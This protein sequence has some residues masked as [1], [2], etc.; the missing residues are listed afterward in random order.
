MA[1]INQSN[2]E[3]TQSGGT[4]KLLDDVISE[5]IEL[6]ASDL[7]LEPNQR[8]LRV[9]YRIDGLLR[10]AI[11]IHRLEQLALVSRAKIMVNLNIAET[12]LP[13]DGRGHYKYSPKG[14]NTESKTIDLRVSVIPTLLGE[15]VTIRLLDQELHR[16][17][18]KEIGLLADDLERILKMLRKKTGIILVTGPTGSG[19]T[20]TLYAALKV[21]AGPEVNIIT[22][23]DPVEYQLNGINQIQVNPK[24][25]MTFAAGLRS[26]LRQD[27]DIIFIGEI[28]DSETAKVAIQAAL[29]GHLVL[30]TLHTNNAIS[31]P[32]RL[33]DM[34]IEPYLIGATLIGVIAQ[35][36]VR[37]PC[38]PCK[39]CH[40][41]GY[42]GRTGIYEVLETQALSE[43]VSRNAPLG[44]LT[45]AAKENGF[46]GMEE[47]LPRLISLGITTEQEFWRVW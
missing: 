19:K 14:T 12:R 21:L 17:E 2:T 20:S 33:I 24:I 46:T 26:I 27:P 40:F 32:V 5:A 18:L 37:K 13:Q 47:K 38:S 44:L 16:L 25:G 23:E 34:G 6:G 22:I 31:A 8:G 43:L 36:L 41:T 3:P 45:Q 15:K 9:R 7:H 4:I 35:R 28:R 30:A 1:E 10:D 42:K 11:Q 39:D 29:T